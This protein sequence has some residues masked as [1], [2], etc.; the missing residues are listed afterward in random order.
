MKNIAVFAIFRDKPHAES[1]VQSLLQSG[2]RDED[3]SMMLADN[4]GTKDFAHEKHTKAPEGASLGAGAGAIIGGTLGLLVGIG[5]LAIPGLGALVAAG[6]IL[7]AFAGAGSVGVAGGI[8]GALIGLGVPEFEAKR[9][10]GL[11]KQGRTLLSVHCDNS[12]WVTPAKNALKRA[13]GSD[14]SATG[15]A[16]ADF[17]ASDKPY[18][19]TGGNV[20]RSV[21]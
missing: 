12:E 16:S 4:M 7:S 8:V 9:Y 20:R 11:I 21:S 13:G 6:P 15:E 10:R 3:V 14:I 1:G 19:P 18:V 17:A 5:A 2:F